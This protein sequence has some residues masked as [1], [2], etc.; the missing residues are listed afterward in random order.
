MVE[1]CNVFY[2]KNNSKAIGSDVFSLTYAHPEWILTSTKR[3]KIYINYDTVHLCKLMFKMR[4]ETTPTIDSELI[5]KLE[6][7]HFKFAM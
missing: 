5:S 3:V 2:Y 7:I 1:A 4:W 6:N